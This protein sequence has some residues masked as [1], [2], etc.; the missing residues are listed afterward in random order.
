MRDILVGMDLLQALKQSLLDLDN[1]KL[2]NPD[3][4]GILDLRRSLREQIA[5]LERQQS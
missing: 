2:L 4:L 3:D 5:A 1:L